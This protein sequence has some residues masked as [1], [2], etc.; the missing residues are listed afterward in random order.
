MRMAKTI[1]QLVAEALSEVSK[2]A[3]G[4]IVHSR[5]IKPKQQAL[6][7]KQGYLKSIIKGW[8]LFDADL[9]VL[10]AGESA[11]W[12]ESIWSFIG[13]YLTSRFRDNYWLSAE[14]SLDIHTHNNSIPAQLVVYVKNGTEDIVQLPNNMTLLV[15][16]VKTKPVDLIRYRDVIVFPLETA[17]A[18]S[19]PMSF[20]KHPVSMQVALRTAELDELAAALL[21]SK[22]VASAGRIIGAYDALTM[23]AE[24]K[25]L[26]AIIGSAFGNIKIK[27]PFLVSPVILAKGKKEN[28]SARRIRIIWK[29]MREEVIAGFSGIRPKF[30]FHAQS[31]DKILASMDEVYVHDAY[32]SLSI[33][34]YAVTPE[35]IEKVSRGDWS[36]ETITQDNDA[37]NALAARGYYDAFNQ[38]KQSLTQAYNQEDLEYLIDVGI[39]QWHTSMFKPCV[40]AGIISEIDLAGYRKGPIYIR[41]SRHVPPASEQLMDCMDA[42]KECMAEE[43]SFVVKAVLGHFIFG[44]IHPYFDGNGRTARFLMNFL[45]VA[46]GYNWVIVTN[47][48]RDNYL[49]VLE[50]ASVGKDIK[51][52]VEF[53]ISMM[54]FEVQISP[55][56]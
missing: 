22:N 16:N 12:Y 37:K 11:L 27:N 44:Y 28:T 33:E 47:E 25:K 39:T 18:N 3:N 32:H 40:T 10:Q 55:H 48:A 7:V 5:N 13:Q 9:A 56:I 4:N 14:A 49:N 1:N 29:Q 20:K 8:Y 15:T 54:E 2:S 50:S 35:L 24:C 38:V 43:E 45:F 53:I 23:R 52:F 26:E 42:L 6:L 51:P 21:R 34:G 30:D 41:S 31:L 46:G 36:P 19:V 17:L